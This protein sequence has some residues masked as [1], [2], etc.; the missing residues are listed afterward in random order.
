V[1]IAVRFLARTQAPMY[2]VPMTVTDRLR[3]ALESC[4]HSRYVVS[5]DSKISESV[6]SRFVAGETVLSGDNIDRL[7]AY[8]N[9][10]LTPTTPTKKTGRKTA[11]GK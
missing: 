10:D 1:T 7:A 9:L 5:R 8:L 4:G 11:K 3:Q 2:T 6:L